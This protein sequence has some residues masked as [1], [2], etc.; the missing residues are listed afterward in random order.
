M[1]P[2]GK[3]TAFMGPSG[4]G[5]TT[6]L[7]LIGGQIVPESGKLWVDN[8]EIPKLGRRELF[9][10]RKS[11]GI[12]MAEIVGEI[13]VAFDLETIEM[14]GSAVIAL[15]VDVLRVAKKSGVAVEFQ[16]CS[17]Q[18]MKIAAVNGVDNILPLHPL[19]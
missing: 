1:I 17:S 13:R 12:M 5:K 15:L 14:D 6:L 9:E 16:G 10:I 18:L 3:I 2:R 8:Q 7:R 4:T 11:M 19:S